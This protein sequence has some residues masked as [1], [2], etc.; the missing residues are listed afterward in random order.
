MSG[1]YLTAAETTCGECKGEGLTKSPEAWE[2]CGTCFG[3]GSVKVGP[4]IPSTCAI[5]YGQVREGTSLA[6][7]TPMP[8][9]YTT[10]KWLGQAT[11]PAG[12]CVG[13]ATRL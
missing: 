3:V 8:E 11:R 13:A 10:C 12:P 7:V 5:C 9:R 1:R 6:H 2:V 4:A